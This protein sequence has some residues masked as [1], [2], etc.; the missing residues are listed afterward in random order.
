MVL[1][2]LIREQPGINGYVIR[3]LVDERGMRSWAGVSSSSIYNG[4]RRIE[5]RGLTSGQVDTAKD[6]RGPRG[7]VFRLTSEG[8]SALESAVRAGLSTT[9]EHDPRFNL[10]LSGLDTLPRDD[11]LRCLAERSEFLAAQAQRLAQKRENS[12]TRPS[13]CADLL[14]DRVIHGIKAEQEWVDAARRRIEQ[15]EEPW[16]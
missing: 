5:E 12:R 1:L 8:T 6:D 2:L 15:E 14:F 7:R 13:L 4:L 11:A 16:A 3:S 9:R 10:A